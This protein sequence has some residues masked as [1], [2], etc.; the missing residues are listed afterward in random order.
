M[1][2][3][4][5]CVCVCVI[6][7]SGSS[8]CVC[9]QSVEN[10]KVTF[11]R[12]PSSV[13]SSHGSLAFRRRWCFIGHMH[14]MHGNICSLHLTR[15]LLGVRG[16]ELSPT[17]KQHSYVC[18]IEWSVISVRPSPSIIM[19]QFPFYPFWSVSSLVCSWKPSRSH[20]TVLLLLYLFVGVFIG[21][22]HTWI[23]LNI[24]Q[25]FA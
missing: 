2:W 20:L 11:C 6:G 21:G 23:H 13:T 17:E 24:S 22:L 9:S 5:V 14:V 18:Y 12:N 1:Y 10:N 7:S 4:C 16:C 25:S 15:P 3:L 8:S 19:F